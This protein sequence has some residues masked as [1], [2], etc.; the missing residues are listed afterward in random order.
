MRRT[1][2]HSKQF[3][4]ICF[5]VL[6]FS[7]IN[8]SCVS[9]KNTDDKLKNQVYK[10]EKERVLRL[11]KIYWDEVPQSVTQFHCERSAGGLNDF[12][13]E[14]DYWWPDPENPQ[15]PY[16]QKDGLSNPDNF[17]EHRHAM[18]RLNK[19]VGTMASA[20]IVTGED[21]YI[22]KAMEHLR[23][24]FID[25]DTRMNPNLLYAQAIKGRFTG[26]GIGIIDAIHL[27]EVA[28]SIK[29]IESS[30]TIS[31]A[32][33]NS[34]KNWFSD[35]LN[36]ISNHEYGKAE[37]IHPNNHGTCWTLQA[38]VY[39]ELTGNK[40]MLDFCAERFE[41]ALLPSQM[42]VDGS[43]P[44]ELKRTKP[45][46]YSIFNLDAM[47]SL[48]QILSIKGYDS[49][50]FKTEDG[51]SLQLGIDFL[52]PYVK[53]KETWPYP[54]DV[55]YFDQYPVRQAFLVFGGLAYNKP[56]YISTWIKLD[57][58]PENQEVIRN[59]IVKFPLLWMD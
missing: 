54:P 55:L 33:L 41:T 2:F 50:N 28:R 15:G 18:I 5:S 20:F 47:T 16:I 12:Y 32:D 27:I 8:I 23:V 10:S 42:A 13:S 11:S 4:V 58:N 51:R 52:Y 49:W 9:E 6:L 53:D 31:D 35:F 46:G 29:Q 21:K 25:P 17:S 34:M 43:F 24:W 26:R 56:E 22:E 39:A 19:I 44:L 30:G 36:W 59:M 57:G 14:G 37:M 45:Y 48:A 1:K 3:A 7:Q 40:E 38:A